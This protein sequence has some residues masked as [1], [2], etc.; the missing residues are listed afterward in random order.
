MAC[1]LCQSFSG[2]YNISLECC[3]V[4]MIAGMPK[5]KRQAV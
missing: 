2:L 3:K 4:R 1:D 5:D